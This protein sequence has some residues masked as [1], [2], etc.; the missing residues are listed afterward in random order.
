[1]EYGKLPPVGNWKR[2]KEKTK[3]Y[4]LGALAQLRGSCKKFCHLVWITSV[5]RIVKHIFITNFTVFPVY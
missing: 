1:M 3:H 4:V 2:Y 5:L